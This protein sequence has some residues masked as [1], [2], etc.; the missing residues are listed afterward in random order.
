[1]K[2]KQAFLLLTNQI[3]IANYKLYNDL[4]DALNGSGEV[5]VLFHQSE[6]MLPKLL[7][8]CNFYSFSY[9]SLSTLKYISIESSLIPGSNHFPVLEFFLNNRNYSHYWCIEDDVRFN[10]KWEYFFNTVTRLSADFISCHIA[11]YQNNSKWTWWNAIYIPNGDLFLNDRIQSF[12]PIYR[13]SHEALYFIHCSLINGCFGHHEVL[14]PTLLHRAGYLLR[15][16]GG[17]GE[18]AD[19]DFKNL[20]YCDEE[21]ENELEITSTVRWRPIMSQTGCIMNK[22][23]HPVKT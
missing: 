6:P 1:M 23:Y 12:N 10:G 5:F 9:D 4:K 7:N 19:P 18:F 11:R 21:I 14:I 15:D 3:N 13:I 22:L 20:F 2:L 17:E 8:S 16:F